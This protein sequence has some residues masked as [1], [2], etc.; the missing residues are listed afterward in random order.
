MKKEHIEDFIKDP[1]NKCLIGYTC[2][3]GTSRTFYFVE[4]KDKVGAIGRY[5]IDAEDITYFQGII[6]DAELERVKKKAELKQAKLDRLKELEIIEKEEKDVDDDDELVAEED[7]SEN[8][9]EK[10]GEDGPILGMEKEKDAEKDEE[11]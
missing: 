3:R 7:P 2:H 10:I 11:V 9:L 1:F 8:L 5:T 6:K 4:V